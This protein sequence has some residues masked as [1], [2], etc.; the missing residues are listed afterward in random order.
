MTNLGA[1]AHIASMEESISG[2]PIRPGA[3]AAPVP[4]IVAR[5]SAGAGDYA[6]TF[7]ARAR[8]DVLDLLDGIH[9]LAAEL[10]R[11]TLEGN[12]LARQAREAGAEVHI[13]F[14]HHRLY[15][16]L[17]DDDEGAEL[18]GETLDIIFARALTDRGESQVHR[19]RY[20][21]VRV[22]AGLKDDLRWIDARS[23]SLLRRVNEASTAAAD[24]ACLRE[25]K[26]A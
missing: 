2:Q 18:G 19:D 17:K 25:L 26:E 12:I 11:K 5:L 24:T 7:T 15:D 10:V 14:P 23:N 9:F 21:A 8:T 16:V 6:Q 20:A 3:S 22:I 1:A 4:E 13:V